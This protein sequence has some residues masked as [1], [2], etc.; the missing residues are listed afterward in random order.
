MKR[1]KGFTMR[2]AVLLGLALLNAAPLAAQEARPTSETFEALAF[3]NLGGAIVSGRV[4]DVAID[5]RNRSV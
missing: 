1:E 2:N 4:S 5:P 3:R